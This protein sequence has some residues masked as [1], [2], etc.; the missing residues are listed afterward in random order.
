MIYPDY[1]LH[2]WAQNGGVNPYTPENINPASIDLTWS[3][4]YKVASVNGWSGV[5]DVTKYLTMRPGQLYLLDT[6]EYITMPQTAAGL[7]LLK[8]S[9]ARRGLQHAFAGYVDPDFFGTLTMEY[10]NWSPWDILIEK[11][12]R[13]MQ[14]ALYQ[15]AGTPDKSY[16][17]TGRYNGQDKPQEAR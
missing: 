1:M 15:M 10:Q 11:G 17:E 2:K 12:Q 3:G 13:L 4:R 16:L 5:I 9:S 8:S 7:L 14:L 6:T